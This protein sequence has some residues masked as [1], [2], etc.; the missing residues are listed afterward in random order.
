[1]HPIARRDWNRIKSKESEVS[2]THVKRML[3]KEWNVVRQLQGS[4]IV[5]VELRMSSEVCEIDIV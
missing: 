2:S 5:S 4:H 3:F 1:M